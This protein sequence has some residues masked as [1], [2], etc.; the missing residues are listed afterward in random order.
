M[1]Y[2]VILVILI[3][4]HVYLKRYYCK[5]NIFIDYTHFCSLS[6][7]IVVELRVLIVFLDLSKK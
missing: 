3:S 6:H 7:A 4:L 2:N 5:H 1:P